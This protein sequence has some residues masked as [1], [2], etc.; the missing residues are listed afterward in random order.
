M[1]ADHLE[2][3]SAERM[4]WNARKSILIA[5]IFPNMNSLTA[6]FKK[7]DPVAVYI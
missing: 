7:G 2:V 6:L 1:G 3:S 5:E 4:G